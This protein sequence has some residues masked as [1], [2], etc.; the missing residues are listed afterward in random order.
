MQRVSSLL[1]QRRLGFPGHLVRMD[2]N[3]LP[4]QVL[5]CM[6]P[7]GHRS[8][9]GQKQHWN[10]LMSRDF[11][12]LIT[13]T[14][15]SRFG[16]GYKSGSTGISLGCVHMGGKVVVVNDCIPEGICINNE[17]VTLAYKCEARWQ[18]RRL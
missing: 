10:D 2:D 1:L 14:L 17:L 3:C 12:P 5:V 9:T 11:H 15:R 13:R 6:L 8:A 18:Q 4:K 7:D 16:P